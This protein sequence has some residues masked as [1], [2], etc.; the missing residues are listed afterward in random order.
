MPVPMPTSAARAPSTQAG[1]RMPTI[2]TIAPQAPRAP[3]SAVTSLSRRAWPGP[4]ASSGSRARV[5][6]VIDLLQPLGRDVRVDL[7]RREARVAQ[8]LLDAA[9]IGPAVKQMRREAVAQAVRA[10]GRRQPGE[11]DVARD[12]PV[13]VAHRQALELLADEHGVGHAQLLRPPSEVGADR[14]QRGLAD[15]A[16]PLLLA[17]PAHQDGARDLIEILHAQAGE[18]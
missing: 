1:S 9:Q 12:E 2:R 13:H 10:D 11:L 15:R 7:R 18:I 5:G 3:P 14:L 4:S 16:E 8:Q 6:L 17:L